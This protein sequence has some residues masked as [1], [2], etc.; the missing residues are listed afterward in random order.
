[1]D[2]PQEKILESLPLTD[3]IREALLAHKGL[4]GEALAC[5]IAYEQ[6]DFLRARFDRLAPSQ[7]TDTYLASARWADQS[8]SS[9]AG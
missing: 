1:M 7:M 9:M 6:G 4:Y 5:V 3:D 8:A 2:I